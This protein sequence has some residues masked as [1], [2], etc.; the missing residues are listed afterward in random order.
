MKNIK[1]YLK[2]IALLAGTGFTLV[3]VA[4]WFHAG[5]F[6]AF[7]KEKEL[8]PVA[9]DLTPL[10]QAR[11]LFTGVH[12]PRPVNDILPSKPYTTFYVDGPVKLECWHMKV[13]KPLGTIIIFHGY[14]GCKSSMVERA[15]ALYDMGYD[16]ILM[17]FSGSGGSEGNITTIGYKE[18]KQ[19]KAIFEH[20]KS[21]DTGPIILYGVSMGAVAIMKAI[22]DNQIEPDAIIVE[23]PFGTMY[24]T[25]CA[26][27][28]NMNIPSF[29]FAGLLLF[30]G[31]I[32]SNFPAFSHKPCEYAKAIKCPVLHLFGEKD[33]KV[34]IEETVEIF[35]NFAG[36]KRLKTYPQAGHESYLINYRQEWTNDVANFLADYVDQKQPGS[37]E[38]ESR[39]SMND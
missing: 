12:N 34:S 15:E 3:N 14:G 21:K 22:Q 18:S 5:K 8:N 4:A 36:P 9:S 1:K 2:P 25:T 26:R 20:Q 29:P 17:D 24:K 37:R 19:V 28:R 10:Q 11:A 39:G 35:K 23:C 7:S 13:D 32:R 33:D 16:I 38:G 31:S 27:F 6:T 30:W